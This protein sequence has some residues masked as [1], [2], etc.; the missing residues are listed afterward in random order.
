MALAKMRELH[1]IACQRWDIHACSIVHRIGEV[2]L[3]EV[4]IAVA[5]SSPH[6]KNSFESAQWLIDTLK[7]T[8]PIWKKE[9][10]TD[11]STEWVHPDNNSPQQ[12]M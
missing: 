10:W 8:V 6:R 2:D 1:Q 7:K 4:S 9:I 12:P 3:G 5:T 11:G